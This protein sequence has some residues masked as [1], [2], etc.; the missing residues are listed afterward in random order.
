MTIQNPLCV[1]IREVADKLG[2]R[3]WELILKDESPQDEDALA[4]IVPVEGRKRA[5]I[6]LNKNFRDLSLGEQRHT[7]VHELLHCHLKSATDIIRL[8]LWE[9]RV[10]SQSVYDVLIGGYRRQI[11]YAVDAIADAVAC[12]FPLI[13]W[14]TNTPTRG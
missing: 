9:S 13:E 7:I 10:L 3:D 6:Y 8:D 1:Y 2:L 11:E 14:D 4:E 5:S 12:H